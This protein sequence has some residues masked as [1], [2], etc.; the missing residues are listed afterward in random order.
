MVAEGN[1][2]LGFGGRF[3][4]EVFPFEDWDKSDQVILHPHTQRKKQKK[5]DGW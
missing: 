3:L 5:E 2:A 4:R 1:T